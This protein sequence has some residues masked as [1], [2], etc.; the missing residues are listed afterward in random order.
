[1]VTSSPLPRR[2]LRTSFNLTRPGTRSYEHLFYGNVSREEGFVSVEVRNNS[3]M[4]SGRLRVSK[5]TLPKLFCLAQM[6][7]IDFSRMMW[8]CKRI[9]RG[10]SDLFPSESHRTTD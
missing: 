3:T 4:N 1:M 2:P 9:G 8:V 10:Q 7:S 5:T 6:K